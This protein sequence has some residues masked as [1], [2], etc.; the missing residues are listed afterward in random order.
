MIY[1]YIYGKFLSLPHPLTSLPKLLPPPPFQVAF[2][3]K[4]SRQVTL[5]VYCTY[6]WGDTTM[7]IIMYRFVEFDSSNCTAIFHGEAQ[8]YPDQNRNLMDLKNSANMFHLL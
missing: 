2:R 6:F 1:I 4:A 7:Y 5:Y 8:Q 3:I